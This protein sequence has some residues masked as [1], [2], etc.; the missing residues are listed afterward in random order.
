MPASS[1]AIR[2]QRS[3]HRAAGRLVG[4]VDAAMPRPGST[5]V[6]LALAALAG[7]CASTSLPTLLPPGSVGDG[8]PAATGGAAEA[9]FIAPGT[10]I[11]VYT[12]VAR[13]ALNCWFGADGPLKA[14]HLFHA[15]AAPPA[16]GRATEI[17]IRERDATLRDQRGPR[18]YRISFASEASGV[19]VGAQALKFD[20]AVAQ[21]MAKDVEVWS[22]GGAGCQ[23]RV[24]MP[25]PP[26]PV[27]S[28]A[29]GGKSGSGKGKKR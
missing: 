12:L 15:D 1:D 7:A 10:P 20:A 28:K 25:P 14:T 18:A 27:A 16:T 4:M 13:G 29:R 5:A 3:L 11:E 17:V 21:A 19:R 8:K 22:K 26:R 9:A 24:L 23:L 6:A 2:P